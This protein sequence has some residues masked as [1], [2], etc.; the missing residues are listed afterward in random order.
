MLSEELFWKALFERDHEIHPDFTPVN[1]FKQAYIDASVKMAWD[2]VQVDDEGV[3]AWEFSNN[4][5]KVLREY[6]K[7][8]KPKVN[9]P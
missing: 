4:N 7:G 2:P 9:R 6:G 5:R 1:S 3:G 8:Y